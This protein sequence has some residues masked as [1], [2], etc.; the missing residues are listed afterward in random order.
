MNWTSIVAKSLRGLDPFPAGQQR[1]GRTGQLKDPEIGHSPGATKLGCRTSE[2]RRRPTR[3]HG[4]HAMPKVRSPPVQPVDAVQRPMHRA[5]VPT[6][7]VGHVIWRSTTLSCIA[8]DAGLSSGETR[9]DAKD[10]FVV[11]DGARAM[12]LP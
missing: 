12:P 4:E 8:V 6:E 1:V 9:A 3:R 7:A 11:A 10:T 5:E 2:P